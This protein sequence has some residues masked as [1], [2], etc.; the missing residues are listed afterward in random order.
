MSR[1]FGLF[2][3]AVCLVLSV[4]GSDKTFVSES[5]FLAPANAASVFPGDTLLVNGQVLST[6]YSDFF[7]Y[8]RYVYV[9]I[10]DADNNVVVRQ[11]VRC[12]SLGMFS[13]AMPMDGKM[14][15]GLYRM[16]G[17]T[18]FMRNRPNVAFP[19]QPLYIGMQREKAV[20][21][22]VQAMLF[23]EG[24]RLVD[25]AMQSVGLFL[26]D[27][28]GMPVCARYSVVANSR[29]TVCVGKTS[30]N[31]LATFT[32]MPQNGA[33]YE[34]LCRAVV[35]FFRLLCRIRSGKRPLCVPT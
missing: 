1:R 19:T 14:K 15:N 33:S 23:P 17:Y 3:F 20:S 9:E 35:K 21:G 12:S 34:V 5:V 8:S 13:A 30:S 29:D 11:K 16:R 2:L 10:A 22:G 4:F 32:F 31:G 27:A 18:Q 24:G 6:D 7:P 28:N 25:E 26:C